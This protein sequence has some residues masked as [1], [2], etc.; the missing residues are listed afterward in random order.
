MDDQKKQTK[1]QTKTNLE[2][3]SVWFHQK[4]SLTEFL[5][6]DKVLCVRRVQRENSEWNVT[7]QALIELN[8][9]KGKKKG[10]ESS[11]THL[12]WLSWMSFNTER[13]RAASSSSWS[14]DVNCCCCSTSFCD[15]CSVSWIRLSEFKTFCDASLQRKSFT[16]SRLL[17]STAKLKSYVTT[18]WISSRC[19]TKGSKCFEIRHFRHKL[20]ETHNACNFENANRLNSRFRSRV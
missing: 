8:S 3:K 15:T 16:G 6:F 12:M 5:F 7:K 9:A 19:W 10:K 4:E 20:H 14:P 11:W 18:S 1:K 13:K 17:T 2:N